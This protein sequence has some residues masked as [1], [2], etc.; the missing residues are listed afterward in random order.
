[1]ISILKNNKGEL[2]PI[3]DGE[4]QL[5]TKVDEVNKFNEKMIKLIDGLHDHPG[6]VFFPPMSVKQDD[7]SA[8]IIGNMKWRRCIAYIVI[9]SSKRGTRTLVYFHDYISHHG[10]S[11]GTNSEYAAKQID[12]INESINEYLEYYKNILNI[13]KEVDHI[14]GERELVFGL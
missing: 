2:M 13:A 7:I 11:F 8:M 14:I 6:G 5:M 4:K 10:Q 12:K 3:Y 9:Q 1:M